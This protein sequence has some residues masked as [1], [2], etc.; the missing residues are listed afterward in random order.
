[1][2]IFLIMN[3]LLHTGNIHRFMIMKCDEK[4]PKEE[5]EEE[6]RYNNLL[7]SHDNK[8]IN[9][10]YYLVKDECLIQKIYFENVYFADALEDNF[11]VL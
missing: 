8:A 11:C 5:E 7:Y 4:W 2:T 10:N 9:E 3:K 1:M 6:E